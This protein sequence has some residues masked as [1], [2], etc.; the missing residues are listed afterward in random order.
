[1]TSYLKQYSN[2]PLRESAI[3][4]IWL[5]RSR[6]QDFHEISEA[7]NRVIC[8]SK[9][10]LVSL[11]PI[12]SEEWERVLVQNK[13]THFDPEGLAK[14]AEVETLCRKI[15]KIIPDLTL[16]QDAVSDRNE[17]TRILRLIFEW[18]IDQHQGKTPQDF[19]EPLSFQGNLFTSAY[20][21]GV[22]LL[23]KL[24]FQNNLGIFCENLEANINGCGKDKYRI[25]RSFLEKMFDKIKVERLC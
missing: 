8:L 5:S 10:P 2:I 25:L 16:S 4:L 13:I 20:A 24:Y 18:E 15:L 6:F 1:M 23:K 12:P 17:V 14:S 21:E 3:D 19:E 7:T 22:A 9:E 11:V